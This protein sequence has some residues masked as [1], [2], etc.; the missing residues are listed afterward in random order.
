MEVLSELIN[1]DV[2]RY[3]NE[4][5]K[6]I[7]KECIETAVIMLL[8]KKE[9]EDITIT[10]IVKRAGVSRTTFYRHYQSKED[11]L[12]SALSQ[13]IT[14]TME[15]LSYDPRTEVFWKV[16][17]TEVKEYIH[18]FQFLLR[19]GLGDEILE[20]ITEHVLESEESDSITDRYSAVLWVGAVYNVLVHW[21]RNDGKESIEEIVQ[22]CMRIASFSH[23]T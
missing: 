8:E 23:R 17:F 21:V 19:A 12:H 7:T 5:A 22:V 2:K 16:L 1:R 20:Q 18:P 6:Q 9:F 11:V 13:V 3:S 10:D 4:E 15:K 14:K